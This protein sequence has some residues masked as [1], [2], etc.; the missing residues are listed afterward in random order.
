MAKAGRVVTLRLGKLDRK[1]LQKFL[2]ES[3]KNLDKEKE[4]INP[5]EF[6]HARKLLRGVQKKVRKATPNEDFTVSED[7][8]AY[9]KLSLE[10]LTEFNQSAF[11]GMFFLKRWF[12]KLLAKNYQ[13]LAEVVKRKRS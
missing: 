10:R 7:E 12:F 5:R 13:H 3:V 1:A 4:K 11:D 8:Y 2:D 6:E 9:L